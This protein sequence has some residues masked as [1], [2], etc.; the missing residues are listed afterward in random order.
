MVILSTRV[1]ELD[2]DVS[3]GQLTQNIVLSGI[4]WQTYRAMLSDMGEHRAA[5]IAYNQGTLTIKMLSELH[6]LINSLLTRI[7]LAMAEEFDLDIVYMG[8]PT[9]ERDHLE[10][11]VE[12]DSCF[13][14]QNAGQSEGLY[15]Q[16]SSS[17][18]PDLVVEVDITSPSTQRMLIYKALGVSEL[19]RY[20]KRNNIVIYHLTD[21]QYC[22]AEHSQ[23]FP[24][25]TTVKLN[26]FLTQSQSQN[27]NKVIRSVRSWVQSLA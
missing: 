7:V 27:Q 9:I 19:W 17:L 14:I 11:G 1:T 13:Y 5:R 25:L 23:A 26:Q 15:A 3:D 4:S 6:E 24:D 12:P 16:T 8:S 10:K 22:V 18:P 20:T 2:L 21:N